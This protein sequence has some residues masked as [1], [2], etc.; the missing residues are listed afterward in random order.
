MFWNFTL[1]L[2]FWLWSSPLKEKNNLVKIEAQ[3]IDFKIV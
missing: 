2:D 3:F 1:H